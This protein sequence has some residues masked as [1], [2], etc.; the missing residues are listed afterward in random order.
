VQW[1]LNETNISSFLTNH[2]LTTTCVCS[3]DLLSVISF[4]GSDMGVEEWAWYT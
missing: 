4:P 2:I 3:R 1:V